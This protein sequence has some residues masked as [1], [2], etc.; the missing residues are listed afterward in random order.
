[1]YIHIPKKYQVVNIEAILLTESRK[2]L[3]R[4]LERGKGRG[5]CCN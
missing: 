3:M 2:E 4:A 1:M 5:K